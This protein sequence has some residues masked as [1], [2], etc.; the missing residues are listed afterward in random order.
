MDLEIWCIGD[1]NY[2]VA[3]L[4]C[5]AMIAQTGLFQDLVRLG[6]ILAVLV[7]VIEAAFMGGNMQGG[8]PWG[9]F[10]IAWALFQFMF[11]STATV[12]VYDTYTL[13]TMEV[14]NVPYGIAYAGSFTSKVAHEITEILEQAFST[15]KMLNDG[16]VGPLQTLMKA[17]NLSQGLGQLQNGNV[18][19]TLT[20]YV[21]DCTSKG[22]NLGQIS[23]DNLI[24]Q[25][26]PWQA[27]KFDSGIYTTLT[28]LPGDPQGGNAQTCSDAWNAINNY[29]SN[30][31]WNDWQGYLKTVFCNNNAVGGIIGAS[32]PLGNTIA[33]DPQQQVQDALDATVTVSQN[34]QYYMLAAVLQPALD[35]GQINANSIFGKPEM[36]VIIGQAREQRNAQW[37]AESSLFVNIMRPLTA[38]IEGFLYAI[39]PFMALLVAFVPSGIRLIFK[40]F[41]MFIWVQMWMPV[42]AILN[43]YLQFILQQKLTSLVMDA[44]I[45]LT[46][47]Q[48]QLMGMSTINDWISTASMLVAATPAITLFLLSGSA[49]AM[50]HLASR[51]QHGEHIDPKIAAPDVVRPGAV[52]GM[53]PM[54]QQIGEQTAGGL[55]LHSTPGFAAMDGK[56]SSAQM[57]SQEVASTMAEMTSSQQTYREGLG[58]M[59][60]HGE[61]GGIS[62]SNQLQSSSG[63]S[64]SSAERYSGAA[65]FGQMMGHDLGRSQTDSQRLGGLVAANAAAGGSVAQL[66][67]QVQSQFDAATA[68]QVGDYMR[69]HLDL[70]GG[71]DL[72]AAIDEHVQSTAARGTL[73]DYGD[74]FRQEDIVNVEKAAQKVEQSQKAFT[75]ADRMSGQHGVHQDVP[76]MAI[77]HSM[78]NA[79]KT[80]ANLMKMDRERFHGSLLP[81]GRVA[82]EAGW[83]KRFNPHA[84]DKDAQMWAIVKTLNDNTMKT[85]PRDQVVRDESRRM[86]MGF[87]NRVGMTAKDAGTVDPY[88]NRGIADTGK[89]EGAA[90]HAKQAGMTLKGPGDVQGGLKERKGQILPVQG[91]EV[92]ERFYQ[93]ESGKIR[94]QQ[95]GQRMEGVRQQYGK[96][97]DDTTGEFGEKE[98]SGRITTEAAGTALQGLDSGYKQVLLGALSMKSAK[99]LDPQKLRQAWAQAEGPIFN[100][101]FQKG[102]SLGLDDNLSKV[103]AQ[104]SM[105]PWRLALER[106]GLSSQMP[107]QYKTDRAQAVQARS[108]YLQDQGFSSDAARHRAEQEVFL[109]EKSGQTGMD[110]WA[111]RITE[112][113]KMFSQAHEARWQMRP[114]SGNL[115]K[116][117][118]AINK[119]AQMYRIDPGLVRSVMRAES[120]GDPRAVSEDGAIGL[121]QIMP[122]TASLL[123]RQLS[124]DFK[125]TVT[126]DMV[127]N[128]SYWNIMAGT[129]YLSQQLTRFGSPEQAVRAYH[130][131]PEALSRGK[132]PGP[133]NRAYV[134]EVMGHYNAER[135]GRSLFNTSPGA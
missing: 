40:F 24:Y 15:P 59:R 79:G 50:V 115:Q 82:Q 54:R 88:K 132:K 25:E 64:A 129:K 21:Q 36:S 109:V 119:A 74:V 92:P 121:M 31:L 95:E 86:L 1:L 67:G 5:I 58:Q 47:I 83:F 114:T 78:M 113:E 85:D 22:I 11:G 63:L 125:Q 18:Q 52:V 62:L 102:K 70:R 35:Q 120:R 93:E 123:A 106:S 126:K 60:G 112:G 19:K 23:M 131:G 133:K 57:Y 122:G 118:P 56:V 20:Q 46:S 28:F 13:K 72:T 41:T 53:P 107:K 75:Q 8:L 134:E 65:A 71:K 29:L 42:M 124:A 73:R 96:L 127:L 30:S 44:A 76:F 69:S 3:V 117:E 37:V 97:L 32:D 90:E 34:A 135:L 111:G 99:T 103:Y 105:H 87:M 16:F 55:L 128:N 100:Q 61:H 94:S 4:N 6:L 10:I 108:Q 33:C 84:T 49:I 7:M 66:Q 101:Y 38:F 27:M 39:T 110:N 14:D 77:A 17:H 98:H 2:F 26:N 80:P 68:Q 116:Y 45:P 43:H 12:W 9:R 89:V 91:R 48:G 130:M 104:G 81:P 51:L